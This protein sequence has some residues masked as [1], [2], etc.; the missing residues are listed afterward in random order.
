MALGAI[1]HLRRVLISLSLFLF[2]YISS[3]S[4]TP[5]I[6]T[7]IS[8]CTWKSPVWC[9]WKKLIPPGLT[10][11]VSYVLFFLT[12]I[13]IDRWFSYRCVCLIG[14]CSSNWIGYIQFKL[15]FIIV[16]FFLLFNKHKLLMNRTYIRK[17]NRLIQ[18]TN[19]KSNPTL[20][21]FFICRS[22]ARRH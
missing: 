2:D 3:A 11:H 4:C 15:E 10:I 21:H 22:W 20:R 16:F 19:Q 13:L 14:S 18:L 6:L 9:C 17:I 1:S 7:H 8:C 5:H 12:I